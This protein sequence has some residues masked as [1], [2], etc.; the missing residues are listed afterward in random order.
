MAPVESLLGPLLPLFDRERAAGNA[1]AVGLLVHTA[2]STYRKPGALMLI[3]SNGDYAG[4]LSGGCLEG[5]LGQHARA[6]IET[7]E[8]K[9]IRYDMRGEDDLIWGLGLGCEGAMHILLLRAGPDSNWE[10]L[11]HLASCLAAHQPTA[12]G[13]VVESE[14][15]DLP[16]GRVILR[17]GSTAGERPPDDAPGT[18]IDG[19]L[20]AALDGGANTARDSVQDTSIN[21]AL[22]PALDAALDAAATTGRVGWFEPSSG[23]WKLFALPLSLPPKVL[24]LGAGPDAAPVVDFAA[25]LNWKVTVVDHR[26]AYADPGH[27]PSAERVVLTRPAELLTGSDPAHTVN[28]THFCAAVVMSHHLPSDLEYLRALVNT[29][30]RYIGLLGPAGRREKLL[31]DLGSEASKLR[32]RLH[33]PVG[34]A[35][36]GRTPES[37]A[38]AIVAEIHAFVYGTHVHGTDRVAHGASEIPRNSNV[39]SGGNGAPSL[40]GESTRHTGEALPHE[41]EE[42]PSGEPRV[43][44]PQQSPI[45]SS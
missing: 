8:P 5:D 14:R 1:V 22:D 16:V 11:T 2:G 35:L 17:V 42:L 7:G 4:L 31:A 34:L 10:P 36:G 33:A 28:P 12:V 24:L 15:Q 32:W 44:N 18:T 37:I 19:G 21:G 6:V 26:P 23:L 39:P 40:V 38:L 30:I 27:F 25:R 13:I 41:G 3:A 9:M 20:N 29:D 45:V 43:R